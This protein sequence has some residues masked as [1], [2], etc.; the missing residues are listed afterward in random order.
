MIEER[1]LGEVFA[2]GRA[3][4]RAELPGRV[5]SVRVVE[6]QRVRRGDTLVSLDDRVA[7]AELARAQAAE[8][9]LAL[10]QAQASLE[11][12]R[13][14]ELADGQLVSNLEATRESDE[15]ARLDAANKSA[16]AATHLQQ[17]RLRQLQIFAPFDGTVAA[18]AVDPGDWLGSGQ[19]ALELVTDAA[20]FV[21]VRV[22][23][24]LLNERRSIATITLQ[25]NGHSVPSELS[26]VVD[27]LDRQTRT[28]LLRVIPSERHDWLRAG[29]TVDVVFAL[30]RGGGM[31]VHRDALVRGVAGIRV[32]RVK[33]GKAEPVQV[34][35]LAH[36]KSHA[37][38]K[39]ELSLGDEV[40]TKGNERLRPGQLLSTTGTFGGDAPAQQGA[41]VEPTP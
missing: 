15:A 3:E 32:V 13:Y 4:V 22:P 20:V 24:P 41:N 5:R 23:E 12:E 2:E 36:N 35:V 39:G 11:A 34:E 18:R 25:G 26:G 40:V 9:E 28:A 31:V 8:H 27:A 37:L 6:G 1:F 21:L 33:D 17:E 38:I 30:M 10:Q 14:R 16:Q 29:A 7:R 19:L